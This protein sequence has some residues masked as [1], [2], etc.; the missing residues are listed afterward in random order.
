MKTGNREI[1]ISSFRRSDSELSSRSVSRCV[2]SPFF[3]SSSHD[4]RTEPVTTTSRG[5][6][7]FTTWRFHVTLTRVRSESMWIMS[8]FQGA[9]V[10]CY[11]NLLCGKNIKA[12][13]RSIFSPLPLLTKSTGL[14]KHSECWISSPLQ[15][16]HNIEPAW[17]AHHS[18]LTSLVLD[19]LFPSLFSS[20]HDEVQLC[21]Q[22][23][24]CQTGVE[25]FFAQL[26]LAEEFGGMDRDGNMLWLP[27]MIFEN[28]PAL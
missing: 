28:L 14:A 1:V 15:A 17:N 12:L 7:V 6:P 25:E 22:A 3:R 5:H 8:Q 24:H 16:K 19:P 10:R 20:V 26:Q 2:E 21:N 11:D 27:G 13:D 4:V 23:R 18:T 9:N